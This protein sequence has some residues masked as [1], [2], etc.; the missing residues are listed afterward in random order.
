MPLAAPSPTLK[1]LLLEGPI[2][3][4]SPYVPSWTKSLG[5][6]ITPNITR[7]G[8]EPFYSSHKYG[9]TLAVLTASHPVS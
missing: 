2:L 8:P 7:G 3:A 6:Q 5:L 1:A 9:L 4:L